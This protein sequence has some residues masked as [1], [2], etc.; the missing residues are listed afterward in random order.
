MLAQTVMSVVFALN[1]AISLGVRKDD[2]CEMDVK[3]QSSC[4]VP[5]RRFVPNRHG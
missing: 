4:K 3:G 1:E 5:Q 2:G